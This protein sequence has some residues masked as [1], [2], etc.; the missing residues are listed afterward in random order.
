MIGL[1]PVRI[2]KM[3][4]AFLDKSTEVEAM[5]QRSF[6]NKFMK[7]ENLR[8]YSEKLKRL[9]KSVSGRLITI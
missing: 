9:Q 7:V 4:L 2:H 3:L 1:L 6:L 8:W 5:V